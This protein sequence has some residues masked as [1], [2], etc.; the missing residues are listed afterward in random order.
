MQRI[1]TYLE[2]A[3]KA[4]PLSFEQRGA[5]AMG[6]MHLCATINAWAELAS[7]CESKTE[8]NNFAKYVLKEVQEIGKEIKE[9][10]NE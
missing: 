5:E 4:E 2:R 1:R 3:R 7:E 10:K 8:W 9:S 6:F